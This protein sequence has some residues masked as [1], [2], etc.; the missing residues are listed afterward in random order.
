M[1]LN[2]NKIILAISFILIFTVFLSIYYD[3]IKY[4]L[5][6]ITTGEIFNID[7][8]DESYG[9]NS[10]PDYNMGI[11][12]GDGSNKDNNYY[13]VHDRTPLGKQILKSKIDDKFTIKNNTY[14]IYNIIFVEKD[15]I[16]KEIKDIVIKDYP[17]ASIQVCVPGS[18]WNK[19]IIAKFLE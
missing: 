1:K 8:V 12:Y 16:F 15:T 19:I 11:W 6:Y 2:K 9:N 3:T 10:A 14:Q 7:K 5:Y 13:V 18:D 4:N 17:T